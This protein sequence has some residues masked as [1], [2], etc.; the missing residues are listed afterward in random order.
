MNIDAVAKRAKVSTAT[1]SRVLNGSEKVRERTAE[2]VRHAVE[3]MGYIP[4]LHARSLSSGKSGLYGLSVSDLT[5]PFFPDLIS[6]FERLAV[7]HGIEVIIAN[8][9]YDPQRLKNYIARFLARKVDGLGIMT[10]EL[11]P[12]VLE[13]LGR[14]K[15]PL[16][17]L[18]QPTLDKR[19]YH[20]QVDYRHGFAQAIDHLVGLGH[21][22]IAFL[23]GFPTLNSARR[24][25]DAVIDIMRARKLP[26]VDAW[27]VFGDHKLEGGLQAMQEILRAKRLPTAVLASNDLMAVGAMG[28]LREKGLRVPDDIS[29]V[30]FDDLPICAMLQPP[31]TTIRLSREEIATRAFFALFTASTHKPMAMQAAPIAPQLI[32]RKTTSVANAVVVKIPAA[33]GSLPTLAT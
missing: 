15:V 14:C 6:S 3:Q 7:E 1:V 5:N 16:V 26:V 18:N 30:G 31:L 27:N 22:D 2:R 32:I 13:Q 4:N 25:R 20:V 23:S 24:R 21:R 17:F 33:R 11:H 29:V 9:N 8:T 12:E 10:S 28:A 19:M